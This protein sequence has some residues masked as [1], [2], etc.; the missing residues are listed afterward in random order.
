MLEKIKLY[1]AADLEKVI[2]KGRKS[3]PDEAAWVRKLLGSFAGIVKRRPAAYRSF[4]PYWWPLK[5]LMIK[6]GELD[7]SEVDPDLVAQVTMGS[8][9]LD[10]SAAWSQHETYSRQMMAGNT[11]TVDT[12]SGDTVE[13][14]LFDDA[15]ECLLIH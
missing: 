9:A 13:Y 8:P 12:E 15:M 6:A 4:G 7:A 11:F 1:E 5:A 2:A 14:R 10:V 3:S